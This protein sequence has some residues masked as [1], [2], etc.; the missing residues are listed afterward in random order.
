V[1]NCEWV[2]GAYKIS[3]I[4]DLKILYLAAESVFLFSQLYFLL[5]G[6]VLFQKDGFHRI[7]CLYGDF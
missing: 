5:D 3:S 4:G 7:R 1:S 2:S 6:L